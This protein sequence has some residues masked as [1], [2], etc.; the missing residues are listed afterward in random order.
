MLNVHTSCVSWP[1]ISA[2][3]LFVGDNAPICAVV[4]VL[5]A[6]LCRK[7]ISLGDTI[8]R[9][10]FVCT[11]SSIIISGIWNG[12]RGSLDNKCSH[13]S[14]PHDLTGYCVMLTLTLILV[15]LWISAQHYSLALPMVLLLVAAVC[16]LCLCGAALGVLRLRFERADVRAETN[17]D[18]DTHALLYAHPNRVS[19]THADRV[20]HIKLKADVQVEVKVDIQIETEVEVDIID[21]LHAIVPEGYNLHRSE[22]ISPCEGRTQTLDAGQEGSGDGESHEPHIEALN[23]IESSRERGMSGGENRD[24]NRAGSGDGQGSIVDLEAVTSQEIREGSTQEIPISYAMFLSTKTMSCCVLLLLYVLC[25]PMGVQIMLYTSE[26]VCNS[27]VSSTYSTVFFSFSHF[28]EKSSLHLRSYLEDWIEPVVWWHLFF[29]FF[30]SLLFFS[31]PPFCYLLSFCT[32]PLPLPLSVIIFLYFFSVL[33]PLPF[34]SPFLLFHPSA[35]PSPL[36]YFFHFSVPI[37]FCSVLFFSPPSNSS[38]SCFAFLL[39][40]FLFSFLVLFCSIL[41]YSVPLPFPLPL[42][43]PLPSPVIY[44]SL[45]LFYSCLFLF[46]FSSSFPFL[47]LFSF[48]YFCSPPLSSSSSCF[49]FLLSFF[50]FTFFALF[51]Y[52]SPSYFVI[53]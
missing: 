26:S 35:T 44:F 45:L 11:S 33:L 20:L 19:E 41:F 9:T 6:Y 38:S 51:S 3:Y 36:C 30:S 25:S 12:N 22:E 14:T 27:F 37:P 42:P 5:Q 17:L 21:K 50:L 10:A 2:Y 46:S 53:F 29:L 47:L 49:L 8:V 52:P 32:L 13:G 43:L 34:L 31:P 39:S 15:L 48:S 4:L 16:A 24:R 1:L 18:A 23:A 40:F 7:H 28:Y